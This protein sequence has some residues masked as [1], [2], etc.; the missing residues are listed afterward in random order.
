MYLFRWKLSPKTGRDSDHLSRSAVFLRLA[1][2][3]RSVTAPQS[4]KQAAIVLCL[5]LLPRSAPTP[6][7]STCSSL[8]RTVRIFRAL[9]TNPPQLIIKH[10]LASVCEWDN[11]AERINNLRHCTRCFD[12]VFFLQFI[13]LIGYMWG[14]DGE[15]V[16][17][18]ESS[19]SIFICMSIYL[20]TQIGSDCE[21]IVILGGHS[22]SVDDNIRD[23]NPIGLRFNW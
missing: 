16:A 4:I 5:L 14:N 6:F 13:G 1:R 11:S 20:T 9:H 7:Y 22:H 21:I 3:A 2:I 10:N 15:D 23:Y 18:W 8:S 17:L 19:L 12:H